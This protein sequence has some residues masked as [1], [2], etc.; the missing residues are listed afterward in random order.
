ME[1][2]GMSVSI[3][4]KNTEIFKQL[5]DLLKEISTEEDVSQ[6]IKDKINKHVN[7]LYNKQE[8]DQGGTKLE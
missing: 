2:K 3:N 8:Y 1:T 4:I 5:V 6:H 7:D